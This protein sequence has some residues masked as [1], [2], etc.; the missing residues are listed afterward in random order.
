MDQYL[1][2]ATQLAHKAGEIMLEH[3]Q[4]GLAAELKASEGNSPVT[5]A[6]NTINQLV[7]DLVRSTYPDHA[8]HGEEQS[9]N[10]KNAAYTWVCDPIDGTLPY[11]Q[12]IPTNVFALAL[13]DNADG[14]PK[15]AVVYDPYMK[16]LFHATQSKGAY[17]NDS[18]LHVNRI[19]AFSDAIVGLSSQ[20]SAYVD[21]TKLKADI[22]SAC[23]RQVYLNSSI[24]EAMLVA[25]GQIAAKV[26]VGSGAYDV[27]TSKL[28][29]EEAGGKVTDLFGDAQRYDQPVRGAIISNGLVHDE[30]VALARKSKLG[31]T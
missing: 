19:A 23:F 6:D 3:F 15:V 16:R 1:E 20:R 18:E 2:F 28:I 5:I 11:S 7:I 25:S 8:V 24:Y 12:G 4:I 22:L 30:L 21:A 31:A 26:H 9:L 17:M 27:V 29:V 14:Q 10:T 13:V